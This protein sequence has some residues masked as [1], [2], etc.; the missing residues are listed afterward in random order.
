MYGVVLGQHAPKTGQLIQPALDLGLRLAN[1]VP[2]LI[3]STQIV[4][5]G[6]VV[7]ALQASW[8]SSVPL[9]TQQPLTLMSVPAAR[10]P[11]QLKLRVPSHSAVK[12]GTVVG[13][14]KVGGVT[15]PVV[16][17]HD[18]SGPTVRWRLTRM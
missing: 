14:L 3:H 13:E 8:R 6:A 15:T 16:V 10:Y 17:A 12:A 4:A 18:A 1:A 5:A 11:A 2:R 7:G 9:V